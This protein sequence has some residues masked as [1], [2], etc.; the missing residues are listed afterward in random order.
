MSE[1]SLTFRVALIFLFLN[2]LKVDKAFA[3]LAQEE[4]EDAFK[5]SLEAGQILEISLD[6][7]LLLLLLLRLTD[8]ATTKGSNKKLET[9][10]HDNPR[11]TSTILE[12]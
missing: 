5:A 2:V 1:I 11:R 9:M 12:K 6:H 8:C 4:E 10:H 7:I 3:A